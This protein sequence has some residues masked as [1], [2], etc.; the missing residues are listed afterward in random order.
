MREIKFKAY[1]RRDD[2][3]KIPTIIEN[4][5]V[6]NTLTNSHSDGTLI[7]AQY[8]GLKD[9]NGRELYEFDLVEFL[10]EDGYGDRS[11]IHTIRWVPK[12]AG[13]FPWI[14][15][16]ARYDLSKIKFVG[17][18]CPDVIAESVKAK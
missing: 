7:F 1:K 10:V 15:G 14:A 12:A 9:C 3:L 2:L 18:C 4:I 13:F 16:D 5:G 11:E 8:T 17:Y 6:L